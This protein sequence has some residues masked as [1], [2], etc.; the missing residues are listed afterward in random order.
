[1]DLSREG[2]KRFRVHSSDEG[3]PISIFRL[4]GLFEA[5]PTYSHPIYP[6]LMSVTA[7]I[8]VRHDSIS[9]EAQSHINLLKKSMAGLLL[10]PESRKREIGSR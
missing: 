4:C 9:A 3:K 5:G 8:V 7:N 6:P 2:L 10:L 1:M